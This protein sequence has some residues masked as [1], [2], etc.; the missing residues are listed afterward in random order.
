MAICL[1]LIASV[2]SVSALTAKA[3]ETVT[4]TFTYSNVESLEG[5]LSYTDDDNIIDSI[6]ITGANFPNGSVNYTKDGVWMTMSNMDAD[7]VSGT[8][9]VTVTIKSGAKA[10]SKAYVYLNGGYTPNDADYVEGGIKSTEVIEITKAGE[11]V[12]PTQPGTTTGK[13][14]YTK[15]KEQIA[16]AEGLNQKEYTADSWANLMKALA[17][18]RAH[19]TSNSQK[20]VDDATK[21][22]EEAIAA[23]VK[24]DY[25]KLE[26]ALGK[27]DD[28]VKDTEGAEVWQKFFDAVA[29]GRDM[30]NSNDQAAVDAA[31]DAIEEAL[32][33]LLE[34][35]GIDEFCT[36][37]F[38]KVWPI[39]FF[40]SLIAN[41]AMGYMLV[42]KKN[43]KTFK[44]NTPVVDYD[45]NDDN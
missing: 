15:L 20:A 3:G 12:T 9:T 22:L 45:I 11:V 32:K 14:D 26:A 44:D 28:F 18:A 31:A 37:P 40:I 33:E 39:L 7:S 41:I 36:V 21:A 8:V 43:K 13:I 30:L 29:H 23:L 34:Y 17:D 25:S 24:M 4:V 10:G 27:A 5:T 2:A 42:Q 19:L 35:L 1:A 16:I 38:H 6:K